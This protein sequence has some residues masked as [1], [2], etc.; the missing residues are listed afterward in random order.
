MRR[1]SLSTTGQWEEERVLK[2]GLTESTLFFLHQ[3]FK[4]HRT[5]RALTMIGTFYKN[6]YIGSGITEDVW[7][8]DI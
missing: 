1:P 3:W 2:H 4:K 7:G 8:W 6:A 5:R